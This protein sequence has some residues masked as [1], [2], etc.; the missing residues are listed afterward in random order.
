M[1]IK[2]HGRS[3]AMLLSLALLMT[4]PAMAAGTMGDEIGGYNAQMIS[5]VE[6][7]RGVYW[8]GNDYRTENYIE[9]AADSD[10]YPIAVSRDM[11]CSSGSL[12]AMAKQLEEEGM[13]VVAGI[14]GDYFNLSS[15][16]PV[17]IVVQDGV[18]RSS[19]DGVPAVGF[20]EDGSAVF[21]RPA[22]DMQLHVGELSRRIATVNKLRGKGFALFTE[23]FAATTKNTGKGW[24]VICTADDALHMKGSVTLTVEEVLESGDA[25]EIPE[26]KLVLSL[27]EDADD[28]LK[29]ALELLQP[30]TEFQI[31]TSCAE[32]W[33]DVQ[34]AVGSLYKLITEGEIESDLERGLSPRTAVGVKADGTLVL[35]TIDGRQSGHSVG[36]TLEQV[37]KRMLELGCVEASV[38]DGGGSTNLSALLPGDASISQVNSP[39]EGRA[40]NVVNFIFLVTEL[41]PTGQVSR[42]AV[43][44][45]DGLQILSGASAPLTV[46]AVDANGFAAA[47][48]SGVRLTVPPS[49][50]AVRDG[51]FYAGGAGSGKI[52]ASAAGLESGELTVHVVDTP[53]ELTVYGER[54]GKVV[55]SLTLEP[56]QEVDLRVVAKANHLQL[57]ADDL[58]FGWELEPEAGI[59]DETGHLTAA[60]TDGEGVLTVYAGERAVYIPI[61]VK[62]PVPFDDVREED[63]FYDAVKYVYEQ[64]LLS[65]TGDGLFAPNSDMS[66]S[67]LVTVLWRMA[68]SPETDAETHFEDVKP[69]DWFAQAVSWAAETGVVNGVTPECFAPSDPLTREQIAAMLYRYHTI[70]CGMRAESG[71]LSDFPDGDAVSD[72]AKES[73]SWATAQKIISG[74]GGGRI[75]PVEKAT[76]A[77]VATMIMRYLG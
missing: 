64:E 5:G 35:Y 69:E 3:L 60:E 26:G 71:T 73:V 21:G 63:W 33:E 52:T 38:M 47:V 4:I 27:S 46:K 42:L 6:L 28:W 10:V 58:C 41:E 74:R 70:V 48:P 24:D 57:I 40:R 75:Q 13:H 36:A 31:E 59:V 56:G 17:G 53:D 23:D 44:P 51:V 50:G 11:L 66:R 45:L 14:N 30:G 49:I 12:L 72:W 18:L 22:L 2:R 25:I 77:E 19:C 68:G 29:E 34:S 32:D 20:N 54:Y 16:V 55:E 62:R 39:S 67:M 43:Y 15:L 37:A 1:K 61:T 8:T 9:C 65:G 76:R 7:A